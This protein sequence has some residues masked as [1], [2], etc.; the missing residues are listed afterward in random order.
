MRTR[1]TEKGYI[2]CR[3]ERNMNRHFYPLVLLLGATLTAASC[4]QANVEQ[5]KSALLALDKEW[6][7][8]T[9]DINK[10]VSYYAPDATVYQPA[11][12]KVTGAQAIKAQADQMMT[13]PGF[14]LGWTPAKAD[15][16]KGGDVG[17]T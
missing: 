16:G 2:I 12:A 6:S 17:Y 7:Q 9:K 15:V 1:Q 3:K 10:F 5:E 11:M 8:S 14:S 13:L 4:A